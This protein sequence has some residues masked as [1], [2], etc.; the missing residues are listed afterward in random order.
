MR[1]TCGDNREERGSFAGWKPALQMGGDAWLF[2]DRFGLNVLPTW[3]DPGPI[4][5]SARSGFSVTYRTILANDSLFRT[6]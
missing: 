2:A 5:E 1:F 4:V 6:R 3:P